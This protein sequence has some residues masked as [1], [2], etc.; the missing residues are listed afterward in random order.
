MI[1]VLGSLGCYTFLVSWSNDNYVVL[2]PFSPDG[3][4]CFNDKYL[5]LNVTMW[6][7]LVAEK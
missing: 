7:T 3:V 4:F 5:D 6:P 2:M 1:A